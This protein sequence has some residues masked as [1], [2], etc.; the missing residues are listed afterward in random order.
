[1]DRRFSKGLEEQFYKKHYLRLYNL[2]YS[3]LKSRV[4]AE[5]VMHDTLLKYFDSSIE[6][7]TERERDGWLTRI[8]VN[9][10][11]DQLR[12]NRYDATHV[13]SELPHYFEFE[14]DYKEQEEREEREERELPFGYSAKELRRAV[15]K[16]PARY[17]VVITLLYFEGFD[18]EEVAQI[19]ELKSSS[20]RSQHLRAKRKLAEI[21]ESTRAKKRMLFSKKDKNE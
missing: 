12:K 7:K 11:I 6:F 16:L 3:I 14:S 10:S 9:A 2:S 5:E 20:V 15:L 18:Y 13:E 1:M 17:R 21:L 4:Q 8:C 19:T